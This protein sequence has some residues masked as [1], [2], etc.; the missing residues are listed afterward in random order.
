MAMGFASRAVEFEAGEARAESRST[1]AGS[2][3]AAAVLDIAVLFALIGACTA[4]PLSLGFGS[5]DDSLIPL[6]E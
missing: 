3:E 5:A 2:L 6:G 4:P 1:L